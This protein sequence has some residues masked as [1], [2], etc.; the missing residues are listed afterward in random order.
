MGRVNEGLS[1]WPSHHPGGQAVPG[2]V[3]WGW[4]ECW[5]PGQEGPKWQQWRFKSQVSAHLELGDLGCHTPP[6]SCVDNW[7]GT[8][9]RYDFSVLSVLP[10]LPSSSGC[11]LRSGT[12]HISSSCC[13]LTSVGVLSAFCSLL[14]QISPR[15][16]LEGR[17]K[18]RQ[19][20]FRGPFTD[21]D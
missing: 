15:G 3:A 4:E 19:W 13:P 9:S 11:P 7:K 20:P 2:Q 8:G 14:P 17:Y 6:Q 10:A 16:G 18:D 21:S 1:L 12:G 5:N